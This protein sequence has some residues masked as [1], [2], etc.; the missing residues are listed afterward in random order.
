MDNAPDAQWC[1]F[2]KEPFRKKTDVPKAQEASPVTTPQQGSTASN[3][4]EK[5]LSPELMR[6]LAA[7]KDRINENPGAGGIPQEFSQLDHGEK[8]PSLSPAIRQ[9]AWAFLFI[10]VFW[11]VVGGIWLSKNADKMKKSGKS[12]KVRV[13]PAHLG[14]Q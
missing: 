11:A 5:E 3:E 9:F 7:Q 10:C 14:S 13:M 12:P 6:K 4:P 2:C 1:D 8:M